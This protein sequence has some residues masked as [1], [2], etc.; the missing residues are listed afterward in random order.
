MHHFNEN[1]TEQSHLYKL[2]RGFSVIEQTDF[3]PLAKLKGGKWNSQVLFWCYLVQ[4]VIMSSY[5][6]TSTN[7]GDL[8]PL[9]K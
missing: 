6:T 7:I 3:R 8:I 2:M 4:S 5:T 1:L 9:K